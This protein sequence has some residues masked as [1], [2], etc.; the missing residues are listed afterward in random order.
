MKRSTSILVFL[1]CLSSLVMGGDRRYLTNTYSLAEVQQSLLRGQAW[2]PYPAYADREGWAAL[3]G[4]NAAETIRRGEKRLDYQ[5]QIN[6]ATDYLAYERTGDRQIMQEKQS[7]NNNALSDLVLA[8]L[9]EGEGRFVDQIINGVWLACERTSWVLSA[10]LFRQPDGRSLPNPETQI[11]DL[12][13]G[14]IGAFLAWT[15]YFFHAEFDKVN[16]VIAHRLRATLH[17]RITIPYLARD[18]EWWLALDLQPDQIVNNWNPWCNFNVLQVVLLTEEE[19]SIVDR[20]VWRSMQSVDQFL[21]YVQADGACEEG[22]SYWGHAAGKLFDY[23]DLLSLATGGKVSLFANPQVRAMGEYFVDAYIG[24]GWVVNFADAT[25][26]FTDNISTLLFRYGRAIGST[27]MM[28]L[29]A[30]LAHERKW[31]I[32]GGTD[33]YRSLAGL[34][35]YRD[36]MA[37]EPHLS[38]KA[39]TWYADTQLCLYRRNGWFLATKGGHNHESHNHNDVGTF[40]L[41]KESLP[42]CI[43]AGVG[44]YTKQTFSPE[45][46]EIWSMQS[47][48]HNLPVVNGVEQH[49]GPEY[50]AA[51]ATTDPRRYRVEYDIAPAYP[52]EAGIESWK[53]SYQLTAKGLRIE[54]DYRLRTAPTVPVEEHLLIWGTAETGQPGEVLLHTQ[55]G[56]QRLRYDPDFSVEIERID[57]SDPRMTK[58]WGDNITRIVLRAN[59]LLLCQKYTITIQ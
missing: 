38:T 36:L 27:D 53:R 32:T 44:T 21:N 55:A 37:T 8:E 56:T 13:S 7:A 23:L 57:L 50:R 52:E 28:Q 9:A 30:L 4:E 16:P 22:P 35:V 39:Y 51:A 6:V 2:V 40:I 10:H 34:R 29:A 3:F 54:N 41:Y 24:D 58:V 45:R 18:K 49:E 11:I 14:E 12:G 33:I 31:V 25:A 59:T 46:Y 15:Y 43:D 17:E 42:V 26:R 5:W 48:Y 1:L 47:G 19:D 20:C